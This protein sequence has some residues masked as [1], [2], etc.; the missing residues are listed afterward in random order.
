M[1]PPSLNK[2]SSWQASPSYWRWW[3]A[4]L[5][6]WRLYWGAEPGPGGVAG[7]AALPGQ[8]GQAGGTGELVEACAAL[9]NRWRRLRPHLRP[10]QCFSWC[11]WSRRASSYRSPSSRNWCSS[12]L[13]AFP[14]I[15]YCFL[16]KTD[17]SITLQFSIELSRLGDWC[18]L[19][20]SWQLHLTA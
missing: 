12:L 16:Y 3:L 15:P 8:G 5:A 10:G 19:F 6:S 2:R 1:L 11:P 14:T 7:A 9:R 4:Q 18:R 17:I 13:E 20:Q